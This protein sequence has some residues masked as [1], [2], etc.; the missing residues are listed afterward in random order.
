M[1]A[2][3]LTAVFVALLVS[4]LPLREPLGQVFNV[5]SMLVGVLVASLASSH[6][7]ELFG[8]PVSVYGVVSY[9]MLSVALVIVV[10]YTAM[11]ACLEAN[12]LARL[13]FAFMYA[14]AS[15]VCSNLQA[16]NRS[17]L[18]L[19][20]VL[21]CASAMAAQLPWFT[22]FLDRH[23]GLAACVATMYVIVVEVF[24]TV[25]VAVVGSQ[26]VGVTYALT[27]ALIVSALFLFLD[28]LEWQLLVLWRI[29]DMVI[30]N[31]TRASSL[32]E[33]ALVFACLSVYTL[34][35][36]LRRAGG[37]SGDIY[38]AIT[39]VLAVT[40][41]AKIVIEFLMTRLSVYEVC[42][43]FVFACVCVRPPL[44]LSHAVS[45]AYSIRVFLIFAMLRP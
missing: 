23:P 25:L 2:T 17:T 5:T 16:R 21:G 36:V 9:V 8:V 1:Y 14:A 4:C 26:P 12:L 11:L 27:I 22:S 20:G 39:Y 38:V 10:R 34:F 32:N 7:S 18:V 3:H 42:A 31:L 37:I 43:C 40:A 19:F 45:Q 44:T 30:V 29:A 13:E 24:A 33:V 28:H 41:T 6:I 15:V 35:G